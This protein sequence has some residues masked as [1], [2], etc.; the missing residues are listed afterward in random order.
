V[1]ST[2]SRSTIRRLPT[3]ARE[4]PPVRSTPRPGSA[5]VESQR[6][7]RPRSLLARRRDRPSRPN[8]ERAPRSSASRSAVS[9]SKRC[10]GVRAFPDRPAASREYRYPARGSDGCRGDP[11]RAQGGH[12]TWL[13]IELNGRASGWIG[14]LQAAMFNTPNA[15]IISRLSPPLYE[16]LDIPD[17]QARTL[18]FEQRAFISLSR[19]NN[20]TR[21][22]MRC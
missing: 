1:Y 13:M 18:R 3:P 16:L 21:H 19:T 20:F 8:A 17:R 11:P 7:P 2:T 4:S 9:P 12:R 5:A 22:W 15:A 14:Q 6:A 10:T